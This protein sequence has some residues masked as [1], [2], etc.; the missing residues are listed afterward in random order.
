MAY[1]FSTEGGYGIGVSA[2]HYDALHADHVDIP[3]AE[4]LFRGHFARSGPDLILTS[5]DGQRH[6][7]PGYFATEN[8]ADLFAPNGA[9]LSADVVDLLAGSPTPG[10]YAQA[11]TAVPP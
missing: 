8:H 4:L 9:H 1:K 2:F 11:H 3:D 6:I 10:Q 7:V 5:Q